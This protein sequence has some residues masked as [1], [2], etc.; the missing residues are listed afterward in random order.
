MDK[1]EVRKR[2][3]KELEI[4]NE[5]QAPRRES[6]AEDGEVSRSGMTKIYER[7]FG[8]ELLRSPHASWENSM[9]CFVL[10][11]LFLFFFFD[12]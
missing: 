10:F 5:R 3:R 8:T 12:L 4:G 7:K 9:F 1:R 6:F 11:C 2:D